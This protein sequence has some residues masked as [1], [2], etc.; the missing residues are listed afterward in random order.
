MAARAAPLALLPALVGGLAA[1]CGGDGRSLHLVGSV[2]RTLIEIVAPVS[3]VL[4]E[5]AVVRGERVEAGRVLAR[6]D[7]T[8][9]DAELARA[10]AALA[11][12]ETA[13]AVA[14]IDRERAEK[15]RR[16]RVASEQDLERA[17][18]AHDEAEA[19]LREAGA[20][21]AA[22]R[23]R[24]ADLELGAPVSG[25]VDQLPFDLGERV[26]AGAVLAVLLSDEEAWVRV[27]IPEQGFARVG[28]GTPASVSIDGLGGPLRAAVL[29]VAREPSFTPHYALTAR[30]RAHL[31]YEARVG[32][33]D[34]PQELRPGLPAEVEIRAGTA[35]LAD[36]P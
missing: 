11:A 19:R 23:K 9:A 36:A 14:L 32:I 34:A 22:A 30:D 33:V 8:L 12:A 17:R 24:R 26:P 2:E 21:L 15:L 31:V 18:L 5:L 3:E 10:E 4:V 13:A 7:P 28:P 16:D 20:A 35:E 29:D 25:V 1:G 27:W 6:L